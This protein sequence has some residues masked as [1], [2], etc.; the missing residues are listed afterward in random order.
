MIEG[1]AARA[2]GAHP[3]K[4]PGVNPDSQVRDSCTPCGLDGGNR[5][6]SLERGKRQL[7]LPFL[8]GGLSKESCTGSEHCPSCA[9]GRDCLAVSYLASGGPTGEL[10]LRDRSSSG[11]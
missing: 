5:A 7:A 6:R 11:C 3:R 4:I 9:S 8:L 2:C 1:P 10:P